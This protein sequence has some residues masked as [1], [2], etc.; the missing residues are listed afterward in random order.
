MWF[1]IQLSDLLSSYVTTWTIVQ[2]P[3]WW[4]DAHPYFWH[5][6]IQSV[7]DTWVSYGWASRQLTVGCLIF[8][9]WCLQS[10][11]NREA[12]VT[13]AGGELWVPE[14]FPWLKRK[15]WIWGSLTCEFLE[16]QKDTLQGNTCQ[17]GGISDQS[18]WTKRRLQ[19]HHV[20]QWCQNFPISLP[21]TLF[22]HGPRNEDPEREREGTLQKWTHLHFLVG[23]LGLSRGEGNTE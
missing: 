14:H 12:L 19:Q 16:K 23:P 15:L 5:S 7:Y 4:T 13:T 1:S 3:Q 6:I 11:G 10:E 8:S 21:S 20:S 2:N 17:S 18:V 9:R 22:Q